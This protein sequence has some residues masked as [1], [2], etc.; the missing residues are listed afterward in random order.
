MSK[1]SKKLIVLLAILAVVVILIVIF[2]TTYLFQALFIKA[3]CS[4]DNKNTPEN[5][6]Q[7]LSNLDCTY[8]IAYSDD[9]D[10][11]LDIY[12]PK[13]NDENLPLIVYIHGG[14]YVGGDK[15]SGESYCQLVAN[16]GYIVA[17][18]NYTLAPKGKFPT[19]AK[20]VNDALSY[21]I[22]NKD[23][24]KIDKDSIFIGGDSA[25]SSLSSIMGAVYTNSD[26]AT[27]MN[28]TPAISP[29][30]LKGVILLCGYF[31]MKT[32]RDTHFFLISESVW[33]LTGKRDFEN[34][35][36]IYQMDTYS[37]LNEN[38][39]DVYIACGNADPFYN[40]NVEFAD[41]AKSLGIEV[42]SAI[43][44]N[45]NGTLVHEFQQKFQLKEALK[46]FDTLKIFLRE[47]SD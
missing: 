7:I 38:Y 10:C 4:F 6:S 21:L 8:D 34:Y 41:K 11:I 28:I 13:G 26:L 45:D 1:K 30:Q 16:E 31:N 40:Q 19:Q 32:L 9:K 37:N 39:P 42:Y 36:K 20:Q 12:S 27:D 18:I 24:Y 14:W 15:Q 43:Y 23:K 33:M 17:N 44:S 2:A 22:S 35:D 3:Y 5:Y 46:A 29:E 47:N 25:G